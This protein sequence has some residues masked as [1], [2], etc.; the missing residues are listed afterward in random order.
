MRSIVL[1]VT[2]LALTALVCA[3]RAK[4]FKGNLQKDWE[5]TL[6]EAENKIKLEIKNHP[7]Q[8]SAFMDILRELEQLKQHKIKPNDFFIKMIQAV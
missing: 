4:G 8:E 1:L 6:E 7:G 2:I 5:K 3:Q